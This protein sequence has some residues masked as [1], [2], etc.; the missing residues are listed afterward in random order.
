M[1]QYEKTKQ[2]ILCVQCEYFTDNLQKLTDHTLEKHPIFPSVASACSFCPYKAISGVILAQHMKIHTGE[3]PYKCSKCEIGFRSRGGLN[4]HTRKFHPSVKIKPFTCKDCNFSTITSESL[5]EHKMRH[6]DIYKCNHCGYKS[7]KILQLTK[8]MSNHPEVQPSTCTDCDF[9]T[10]N[11]Y[12]LEIHKK[13]HSSDKSHFCDLCDFKSRSKSDLTLHLRQHVSFSCAECD[14]STR[15]VETFISHKKNHTLLDCSECD[16][17][18]VDV[19]SLRQ[20]EKTHT[21]ETYACDECGY[22]THV[23]SSLMLHKTR[24][25]RSDLRLCPLCDFKAVGKRNL[26]VHLEEKHPGETLYG[27]LYCEYRS[28][29]VRGLEEHQESACLKRQQRVSLQKESNVRTENTENSGDTI[30]SVNSLTFHSNLTV[31][32]LSVTGSPIFVKSFSKS[33]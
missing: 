16:F 33:H 27:C 13:Q 24:H 23:L 11:S 21:K 18:T 26:Q 22:K 1:K 5:R 14:F 32:L 3:N 2:Y 7:Y 25:P 15:K 29:S 12:I 19:A 6:G 30:E 9:K 8:H 28:A 31:N 20:H 17:K 4:N 10:L